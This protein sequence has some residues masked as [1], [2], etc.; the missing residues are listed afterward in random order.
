M[1]LDL[2]E[3]FHHNRVTIRSS[4]TGGINPSIRHMYSD[5]RKVR[6]CLQLLEKLKLENLITHRYHLED[7]QS[8]YEQID[9]DPSEIIQVA[10]TY[11]G[12]EGAKI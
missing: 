7:I 2:S 1:A 12:I 4:Q 11:D 8:A 10:I 3:E 9:N 5:E 6:H